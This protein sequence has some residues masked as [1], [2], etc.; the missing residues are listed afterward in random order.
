MEAVSNADISNIAQPQPEQ[1]TCYCGKCC[2]GI[3][4]RTATKIIAYYGIIL[5]AS[6]AFI[7]VFAVS[8]AG[9]S[10]WMP[11]YK[12]KYLSIFSFLG[13]SVEALGA[14]TTILSGYEKKFV[15]AR[16]TWLKIIS[17]VLIMT[18][19]ISKLIIQPLYLKIGS[20]SLV[21]QIIGF[22]VWACLDIYFIF[23]LR[24]YG[25]EPNSNIPA[26][27]YNDRT[28]HQAYPVPPMYY[29]GGASINP[30]FHPPMGQPLELNMNNKV[31]QGSLIPGGNPIQPNDKP[32]ACNV[33]KKEFNV[34]EDNNPL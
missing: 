11:G 26:E 27:S 32:A 17:L 4:L 6:F 1:R 20:T 12:E 8:Y 19:N 33:G 30:Y 16:Y 24:S 23:I 34:T 22:I 28:D 2:C 18:S 25:L 5:W 13:Y 10:S 31:T 7:F 14:I 3:Y 15:L 9:G 21:S 29:Q